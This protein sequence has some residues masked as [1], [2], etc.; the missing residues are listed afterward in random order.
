MRDVIHSSRRLIRATTH[1]SFELRKQRRHNPYRVKPLEST[2]HPV[3]KDWLDNVLIPA[4]LT[5]YFD[6]RRTTDG[7]EL[8]TTIGVPQ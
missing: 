3:V 1:E 5:R 4:M 6:F 8:Q 7:D 2:V